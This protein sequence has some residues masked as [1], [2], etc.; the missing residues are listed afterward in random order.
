MIGTLM[1][2]RPGCG[3]IFIGTVM[4]AYT[5]NPDLALRPSGDH[6]YLDGRTCRLKQKL[7][8]VTFKAAKPQPATQVY[9]V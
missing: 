3:L 4:A 5:L 1:P 9:R 7:Q 6:N 8:G 2:V